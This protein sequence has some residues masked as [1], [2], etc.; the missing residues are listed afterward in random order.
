VS[1]EWALAFALAQEIPHAHSQR[2]ALAIPS[3]ALAL[4]WLVDPSNRSI[5][6]A[7]HRSKHPS[8]QA[9]R[10]SSSSSAAAPRTGAHRHTNAHGAFGQPPKTK[11]ETVS[12]PSRPHLW[13]C[14]SGFKRLGAAL[15]SGNRCEKEQAT[16]LLA[17]VCV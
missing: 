13:F 9:E 3:V 2:R 4:P 15:A 7:S 16:V 17:C 14:W 10:A 8:K 1:D 12:K 11:H 5:G 6:G